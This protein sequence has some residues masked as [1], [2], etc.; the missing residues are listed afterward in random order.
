MKFP[1]SDFMDEKAC[2]D[3]LVD[4]LHPGG[5]SCPECEKPVDDCWIHRRDREPLLY[6]QCK[7]GRVFNAFT[8]TYWQGT[9]YSCSTIVQILRGILKG[10]PTKQLAE[11]LGINRGNLLDHRHRLQ[12]NAFLNRIRGELQ[13]DVVEADE[14]YQNAGEK[15]G[16]AP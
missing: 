14:M 12:E 3:F 15:R 6:Y 2:Y 16:S 10:T 1:I 7:C 8:D 13:D 5:F 4:I 11:E 9:H